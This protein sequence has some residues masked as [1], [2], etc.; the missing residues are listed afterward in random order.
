MQKKQK[1]RVKDNVWELE[2]EKRG[3]LWKG[4]EVEWIKI[5]EPLGI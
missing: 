3:K 1:K 2:W 4:K 5:A